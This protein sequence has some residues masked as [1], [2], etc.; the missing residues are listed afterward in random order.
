[1]SDDPV[2]INDAGIPDAVVPVLVDERWPNVCEF[3]SVKRDGTPVTTPL[4]AF[5]GENR[6]TIAISTGVAHPS[7]AERARRNPKVCLLYAEPDA[8]PMDDPPVVLVYGRA[9]VRDADLQA[10][11]DRTIRESRARSSQFRRMPN[12]MLRW[13]EG[14]MTRIW[15]EITPLQILWWPDAHLEKSPQ[16]WLAPPGTSAPPSDPAPK[17]L[18]GRRKP[19]VAA[20]PDWREEV[21][22]GF[23][24]LGLPTL[25]VVD[26]AGYPVPFMA[27][28]GSPEADGVRLEMPA[29]MPATPVGRAC[30]SFSAIKVKNE[31]MVA[32]DNRKFIG[33]A[34]ADGDTVFFKVERALGY[35]N[36]KL[37]SLRAILHFISIVRES[38]RRAKI[39][40]ARRGQ[41]APR[42]R[43]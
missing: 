42:A 41:P 16:Q 23:E 35:M 43:L 2:F 28:R 34:T 29:G 30:L 36:T 17:P 20:P 21:A 6:R 9:T 27:R 40:A 25:T 1:M 15:I 8:L 12:F 14:Y 4:G 7:K 10:N 33:E 38:G 26:E 13:M 24:R 19:L 39:E 3:A 18:Q 5:T 31:E 22:Y 37:D 11:L 32:N